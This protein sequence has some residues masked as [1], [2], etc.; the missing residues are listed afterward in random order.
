M[1][2]TIECPYTVTGSGAALIMVHG[3]GANRSVWDGVVSQLSQQF[4]CI[5]Y[6]LRGH[7]DAPLADEEFGLADLVADLACLQH[8]LGID[9]AHIIGHSLGGMI[10]PAYAR[11]YP[12]RVLS[13]GLL[14]TAAFRTAEDCVRVQQ[15][16]DT[17]RSTG[18]EKNIAT[19]NARWFTAA[20]AEAQ[21]DIVEKRKQQVLATNERTFLNVFDIY[22]T[23]EMSPWLHEIKHPCLV[24]TGE[25]DGGC[26]PRLNRLINSA[27]PNSQLVIINDLKHAILLE[28]SGRVSLALMEFYRSL[29]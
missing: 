17:M 27:L 8:R 3:I 7:G 21:P 26:N 18:V 20:F 22:A 16:V 1:T 12:D 4:Q 24:L 13:V 28:D 6:D 19:L 9:R 10:A 15:V 11:A 25:L 29:P 23:T 5:S 14:S 2:K